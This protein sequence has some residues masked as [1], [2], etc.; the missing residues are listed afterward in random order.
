MSIS[1]V[2][3]GGQQLPSLAPELDAKS[4][5]SFAQTG[6]TQEA[7]VNAIVSGPGL[8]V[9]VK[10][11]QVFLDQMKELREGGLPGQE[12]AF[13]QMMKGYYDSMSATI[14]NLAP[15]EREK[16]LKERKLEDLKKQIK[17]LEAKKVDLE[18][19]MTRFRNTVLAAADK[20][21]L[22]ANM[23]KQRQEVV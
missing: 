5:D 2:N 18:E 9:T 4:V 22:E 14:K 8:V 6:K 11:R 16:A 13:A 19:A 10:E 17:D 12:A 1:N 23:A 20:A 21:L 3:S 7:A 15:S